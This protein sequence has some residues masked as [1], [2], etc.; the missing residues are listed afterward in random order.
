MIKIYC[1][2]FNSTKA[3]VKMTAAFLYNQTKNSVLFIKTQYVHTAYN[4]ITIPTIRYVHNK[5]G[6][7]YVEYFN[8]PTN[9]IK[10]S[11]LPIGMA[12]VPMQVWEKLY[13]AD[14]GMHRGTI[15]RELDKPFIGEEAVSD[16]R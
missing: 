6:G 4:V 7:V 2:E 8:V 16:E 12:Y 5:T 3:V 14:L 1:S 10:L 9:D 13:E 11:E 15:F